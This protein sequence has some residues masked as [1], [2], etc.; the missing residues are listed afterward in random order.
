[1]ANADDAHAQANAQVAL[2]LAALRQEDRAEAR[3]AL[4]AAIEL[5]THNAFALRSLASLPVIAGALA[6]GAQRFRQALAVAPDDLITTFNL[7]QALLE[8]DPDEHRDEAD[9]LLLQVIEAQPYGELAN[10]AKELRGSIASRDLRAEQPDGLRQDA[11][12]YCLQALQLL[13]GMDQQRFLQVLSEVGAVGQG[14][15]QINKPG[16]SRSLK[17]LPGS[18]SDLALACLIYVGM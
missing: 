13:E 3:Q 9:R 12:S 11:V 2:G 10:K 18:W 5:E 16:T 15:L 17:T 8:L 4:E 7:A 6:A 1:V 14:G